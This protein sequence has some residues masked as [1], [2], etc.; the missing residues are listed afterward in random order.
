MTGQQIL[1]TTQFYS[2]L[3]SPAFILVLTSNSNKH[4]A[5]MKLL[6]SYNKI[7]LK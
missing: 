2:V 1:Q 7:A 6:H 4:L 3:C 5:K